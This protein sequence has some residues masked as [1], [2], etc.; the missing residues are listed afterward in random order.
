M[1]S[2]QNKNTEWQFNFGELPISLDNIIRKVSEFDVQ[3]TYD[4]SRQDRL[5]THKDTEMFPLRFMDYGWQT[6][7]GNTSYDLNLFEDIEFN[8]DILSI[9][10]HLESIYDGKVV[11]CE[12]VKMHSKSNIKSHVDGGTMLQLA[13]RIHI[14]LI[15]NPGVVFEVFGVKKHFD[16]GSWYEINNMLPH[17]VVND[18]EFDRVHIIIDLMPNKYLE[19]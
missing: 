5:S 4:T 8:K 9:Y 7:E 15:T 3:W 17:S 2:L 13:R 19:E 12:I 10:D 16:I 18:G 6:G 14:P 11:R 1:L